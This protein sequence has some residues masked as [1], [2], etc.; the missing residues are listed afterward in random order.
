M[1]SYKTFKVIKSELAKLNHRI[2]LKIIQ[3]VP[4]Y[5]EARRHKFLRAQLQDLSLRKSP[6]LRS[7]LRFASLFMF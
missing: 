3:G 7:T 2:D 4:Y 5:N 6:W 1:S